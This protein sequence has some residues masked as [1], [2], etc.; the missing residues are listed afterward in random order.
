MTGESSDIGVIVLGMS[1]SGTSAVTGMFVHAGFFGGRADELSGATEANPLGQFEHL[2]T[3][4][5]NELVLEQLNGSWIDPP[6]PEVQLRGADA[7]LPLLR[8][9]FERIV[10]GADGAPIVVKDPRI[11]VM[12]PLWRRIIDGRLHPV[13]V[14]RDPTEVARSLR[15]RDGTPTALGLA[16]WEL[17]MT[18]LL[19]QLNG[20]CVTVIPY[21]WLIADG[22]HAAISIRTAGAHLDPGLASAVRA[23]QASEGLRAALRRNRAEAGDLADLTLRQRELWRALAALPAGDVVIDLP[24]ELLTPNPL[25]REAVRDESRRVGTEAELARIEELIADHE[26]RITE[27]SAALTEASAALIEERERRATAELAYASL[28]LKLGSV[29]ESRSWRMTGPLRR[30]AGVRRRRRHPRPQKDR[31]AQLG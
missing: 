8:E 29:T 19:T 12:M 30:L 1:R 10:A 18:E 27:A 5:A 6:E 21:A 13:L 26:R 22:D 11:G 4:R 9:A 25:A 23:D 7:A 15:A 31:S 16:G 3:M 20:R 14:V 28:E 24:A 17:H 2:G